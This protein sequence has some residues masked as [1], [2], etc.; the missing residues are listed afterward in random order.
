MQENS[1]IPF[2]Y[3]PAF[4]NPSIHSNIDISHIDI[5]P[6]FMDSPNLKWH[7]SAHKGRWQI[8]TID[9]VRKIF[10]VHKILIY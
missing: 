10:S 2:C 6:F 8:K 5:F 9:K 7:D 4:S 1:K 3:F